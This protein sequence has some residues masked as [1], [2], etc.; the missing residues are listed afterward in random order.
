MTALVCGC[1]AVRNNEHYLS[2]INWSLYKLVSIV[3]A[4]GGT[5]GGGLTVRR[6]PSSTVLIFQSTTT[7]GLAATGWTS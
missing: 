2:Y 4:P 7:V 6:V 3:R 5:A 1:R